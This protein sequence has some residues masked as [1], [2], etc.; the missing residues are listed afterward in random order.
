MKLTNLQVSRLEL[1]LKGRDD[2]ISKLRSQL[3]LARTNKEYSALLTEL[4]TAKA[5]DSKLESQVLELMRNVEVDQAACEEIKKQIEEQRV[6][7]EE[8]RKDSES[9]AVE[10]EKDVEEI[11]KEWNEASKDIPGDALHIFERV[12]ETYDGEA[13]AEIEQPQENGDSYACGGCFM[14]IPAEVINILSG[15]DEIIRCT[16]C[17]RILY[18][19]DKE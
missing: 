15:R 19:K 18:L 10:L 16:S 1:D 7:V 11:Q 5:D 12:A 14:G 9:K 8:V 2:Q 6:K 3:N 17:T 13:M 4:N